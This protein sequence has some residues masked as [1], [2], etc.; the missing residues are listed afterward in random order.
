MGKEDESRRP[1]N[2]RGITCMSDDQRLGLTMIIVPLRNIMK[3]IKTIVADI[4]IIPNAAFC[5]NGSVAQEE[6]LSTDFVSNLKK[7]W[8]KNTT[9][10]YRKTHDF[11]NESW[12]Q[13][14]YVTPKEEDSNW[15]AH[16]ID[17]YE[18]LKGWRPISEYL[19]KTLFAGHK[20]GDCIT[21]DIPIEKL[22]NKDERKEIDLICN[23]DSCQ[24]EATIKVQLQLAQSKYRYRRFGTF[25]DVLARV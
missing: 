14:W 3:T 18:E 23:C 8:L 19:P 11:K 2:A 5:Y 15:C 6:G 22:L 17:G 25:E 21:I 20:E 16:T 12:I 10:E 13:I 1:N 24:L 4:F 9:E 7:V